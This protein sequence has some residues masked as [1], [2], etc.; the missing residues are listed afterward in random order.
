MKLPLLSLVLLVKN[1]SRSIDSIIRSC[2]KT[3]D[4]IDILDT[5]STDQTKSIAEQTAK[6]IKIPISI[7]NEPF[8]DF[9]TSRNRSIA[10]AAPHAVFSL[11]LSGDETLEGA[12][13]L[14]EFLQSQ[15]PEPT[16]GKN[17]YFIW[18]QSDR[19]I[20][21]STRLIRLA[22]D[23]RWT[24][25]VHEYIRSE[26]G[27]H[28]YPYAIDGVKIV[29]RESDVVRKRKRFYQDLQMLHED[30]GEDP[31]TQFYLAQTL[32][33][34]GFHSEAAR[35]Y[36]IRAANE[37]GWREEKF[38]AKYRA[39]LCIVSAGL[40]LKKAEQLLFEAFAERPWR[41]EPLVALAEMMLGQ[42]RY[43]AAIQYA[44]WSMDITPPDHDGL[45]IEQDAYTY[46]P[47]LVISHAAAYV[48]DFDLGEK[49]TR[50]MIEYQPDI[51]A[52]QHNLDFYL[53]KKTK[54]VNL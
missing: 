2:E 21:H 48:N 50:K 18:L 27:D 46:R 33:C 45:A 43:L 38:V 53:S 17:C 8:V 34:L 31:R 26:S 39:A 54:L 24:G 29:H 23:W 37:A 36:L 20:L 35:Y 47:V 4:R 14:R 19:Q 51:D 1:E 12:D 9:S 44:K 5:G 40:D 7:R 42:K 15:P 22:S 11:Q 10:L 49:M 3:I 28:I 32:E 30:Y 13:T 52:H 16:L 6:R 41:A 25:R